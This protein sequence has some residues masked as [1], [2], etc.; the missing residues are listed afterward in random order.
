VATSDDEDY[1]D[2]DDEDD[3]DDAAPRSAPVALDEDD[4]E[5]EDKAT[6]V[7]PRRQEK[8]PPPQPAV[9]VANVARQLMARGEKAAKGE[10][11]EKDDKRGGRPFGG[12]ERPKG[13]EEGFSLQ[14]KAL[15]LAKYGGP[16]IGII[17]V[18]W[19][20]YSWWLSNWQ[21]G[22][23]PGL[24]P[25]SGV[26]T[27]DGEPISKAL[28]QFIP[29]KQYKEFSESLKEGAAAAGYTDDQGHYVLFY[30]SARGAVIGRN[31]VRI[32]ATDSMG[33]PLIPSQYNTRTT[34][35]A[36][37]Q[38]ADN[39]FDWKLEGEDA[40]EFRKGKTPAPGAILSPPPRRSQR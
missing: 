32:E 18:I 14:E 15:Y 4:D 36:D 6:F 40:N 3:D 19:L 22:V 8:T 31:Q 30:T 5:E 16:I 29:A 20:A 27:L 1:D 9:S 37:V 25:V 17:A 7:R 13:E 10:K 2:D 11:E 26:V 12:A 23:L 38:K 28:V 24:A 39:T 33:R 34:L 21:K 35:T